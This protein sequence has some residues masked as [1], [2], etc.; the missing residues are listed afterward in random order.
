MSAIGKAHH[1]DVW[2][3]LWREVAA[4]M[5]ACNAHAART[6]VLLPFFQL[7]AVARESAGKFWAGS[8]LPRIE[9]TKSW[10]Q[11]IAPFTPDALDLSFDAGLDALRA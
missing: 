3:M 7:Q 4:H 1:D 2:L 9:T 5:L 8:F 10:Q 6:V 11:R